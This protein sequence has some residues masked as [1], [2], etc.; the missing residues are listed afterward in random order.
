[1]C[2][3]HIPGSDGTLETRQP[4]QDLSVG[5]GNPFGPE[6][7]MGE[8]LGDQ[9]ERPTS[10]IKVARGGTTLYADWLSPTAASRR[11]RAVVR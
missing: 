10:L 9:L 4:L 3:W 2:S 6:L 7:V 8:Y 11:G 5:C 1:M